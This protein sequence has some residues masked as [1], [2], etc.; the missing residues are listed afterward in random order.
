MISDALLSIRL[1]IYNSPG[2]WCCASLI[3]FK[4]L[5]R[6]I[7]YRRDSSLFI[8]FAILQHS[9]FPVV[10]TPPLSP[11]TYAVPTARRHIYWV[12]TECRSRY[13]RLWMSGDTQI[14]LNTSF[15]QW[16]PYHL[17]KGTA[18]VWTLV[19]WGFGPW[20]AKDVWQRRGMR[21]GR[22]QISAVVA[23]QPAAWTGIQVWSWGCGGSFSLF[24]LSWVLSSPLDVLEP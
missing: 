8:C 7:Y 1:L 11:C 19:T 10:N 18:H 21:D 15:F 20:A 2:L 17:D 16:H 5:Q 9:H 14:T 6:Y 13:Q 22:G 23:H 4:A 24:P 12:L 3:S